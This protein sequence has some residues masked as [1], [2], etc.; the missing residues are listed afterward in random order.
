V[1][2]TYGHDSF[3]CVCNADFCDEPGIP[4]PPS[5]GEYV[6]YVSSRYELRLEPSQGSVEATNGNGDYQINIDT[7]IQY[8]TILGFGG[9]FTDSAGLNLNAL[10]ANA[11][12]NALRSYFAPEGS[13][14]SIIRVPIGGSDFS[15]RPYSLD[16]VEGDD[17]LESWSLAP[18][19]YD[20]K[21][22]NIKRSM[23]LSSE[24]VYVFGSPWSPPSWMKTNGEFTGVGAL[25][26]EY[27]QIY[28]EYIA[29]WAA[30]YEAEGVPIW[31]LTPQNEPLD[32]ETEWYINSC[33]WHPED[34]RAWIRDNLGPTLEAAGYGH[35][36][37]MVNDF[38]RDKLP[39][40]VE[41]LLADPECSKYISGVAVHWY[42][43]QY[44]SPDVLL[45]TRDLDPSKFFLYTEACNGVF[46]DNPDSVYLGNWARAE[47]YAFNII[48]DINYYST[49]W[50][51]WN[52][53][54][55]TAGGPHW[56]GGAMDSPII[57][58]AAADEFLKQPMH[59]ALAHFSKF[60]PR[61]SVRVDVSVTGAASA[62]AHAAAV[63]RADGSVAAVLLSES[64]YPATVTIAIDGSRFVN[65]EVPARSISTF[66]VAP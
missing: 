62:A 20:Y 12:E 58:D 38:N 18:E 4:Q 9:A 15:T 49:G 33:Q 23:E 45:Q 53:A 46:E 50:V 32:Q 14:Y 19:D 65:V 25:L 26:P 30:A 59:Y 35:L 66:V 37:M 8:Q 10:S 47:R 22:P 60:F 27:W 11:R 28:A 34:M 48:E 42:S 21:I 51:D 44:V 40:A 2:R 29:K 7:N 13:Q 64:D 39:Y 16:D 55:D 57:I 54:L 61:G 5:A 52:M 36:V 56:P 17:T 1:Q 31:G 3:V 6:A 43:D 63:V 41:P 24:D